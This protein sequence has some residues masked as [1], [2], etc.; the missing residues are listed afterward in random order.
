[1][2]NNK[3]GEMLLT[4]HLFS[5]PFSL[6]SR[7]KEDRKLELHF[8]NSFQLGPLLDTWYSISLKL[9]SL[10]CATSPLPILP[11]WIRSLNQSAFLVMGTRPSASLS[12]S[13]GFQCPARLGNYSNKTITSSPWEPGVTSLSCYNKGCLPQLLLAHCSQVQPP[14][15]LA[16]CVV[17]S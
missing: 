9:E 10:L 11:Q 7:D 4:Q 8:P 16:W 2:L 17:S 14:C 6:P 12:S 3:G 15:G 5:T 13:F 1:M